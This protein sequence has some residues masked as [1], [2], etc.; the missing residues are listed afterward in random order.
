MDAL[1]LLKNDHQSVSTLFTRFEAAGDAAFTTKRE[2]VD[3]IIDELSVHAAIE[4]Q[5]FYPAL[6][7]D[8]P[9]TE[10]QVLESLEEHHVVKWLLAELEDLPAD[11][12]RFTAKTT[13]L[14]ENVRHHVEE[15]EDDLFPKVRR[16]LSSQQLEQLGQTLAQAKAVVPHRPHPRTPDTPPANLVVGPAAEL[17]DRATDGAKEAAG[18]V[19]TLVGEQAEADGE[20]VADA[21]TSAVDGA[22]HAAS[23]A[24]GAVR[25]TAR[26]SAS[27]SDKVART[28]K[29][30]ARK[31]AAAA[32][33][34]GRKTTGTAKTGASKSATAAKTG[35]RKTTR[36]AKTSARKT[37]GTAKAGA[38]KT[39]RAAKTGARKT[40]RAAK[41]SARTTKRSATSSVNGTARTAKAGAR[42]AVAASRGR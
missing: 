7:R 18:S 40:T 4:E 2:I 24:A 17:V 36:T 20:A 39:T 14:I 23:S 30:T 22:R 12:E 6:R 19:A 31:S 5:V 3:R 15:E 11:D 35:A 26:K 42:K 21:V 41:T 10:S 28:A 33:T 37:T 8:I 1:V 32:K 16:A 34:S 29:A 9:S 25:R 27:S 38:R 13:V